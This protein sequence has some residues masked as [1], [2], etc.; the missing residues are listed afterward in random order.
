MFANGARVGQSPACQKKMQNRQSERTSLMKPPQKPPAKVISP[1]RQPP[2][3][4]KP[5]PTTKSTASSEHC[6]CVYK[7]P[8]KPTLAIPVALPTEQQRTQSQSTARTKIQ[9]KREGAR[10]L[11]RPER[12]TLPPTDNS[13][14]VVTPDVCHRAPPVT[15]RISEVVAC[16]QVPLWGCLRG[17]PS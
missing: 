7:S 2:Q 3:Q 4:Q 5:P 1:H 14:T 13:M 17:V 11:N 10:P 16:L 8:Q 15:T 6:I 12:R 9:T